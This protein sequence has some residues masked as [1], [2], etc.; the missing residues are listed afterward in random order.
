MTNHLLLIHS[1]YSTKPE[2]A[3]LI[4]T[5]NETIHISNEKILKQV[6]SEKQS[7][8]LKRIDSKLS[9]PAVFSY[10][11]WMHHVMIIQ[12][13]KTAES[14]KHTCKIE[15]YTSDMF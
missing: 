2:T 10:V 14:K 7:Q 9:F 15:Q 11:P 4:Q 3:E 12:K 1:F 8:K 13:C 6:A 5:L